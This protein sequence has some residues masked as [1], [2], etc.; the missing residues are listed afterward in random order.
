[1]LRASFYRGREIGGLDIP[2]SRQERLAVLSR[3]FVCPT[4]KVSHDRLVHEIQP[5][6]MGGEDNA[7]DKGKVTRRSM[8]SDGIGGVLLAHS[9]LPPLPTLARSKMK[10]AGKKSNAQ[11]GLVGGSMG[12]EKR[13]GKQ[14]E[15][16]LSRGGMLFFKCITC[17][18]IFCL[19]FEFFSQIFSRR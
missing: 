9:S 19:S 1:M 17:V 8:F 5:A 16:V 3:G 13:R 10:A 6:L 15:S 7:A 2:R 14:Q 18:L 11:K 4:C 12:I